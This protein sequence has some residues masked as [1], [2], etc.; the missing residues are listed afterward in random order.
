M[1][2][3]P[4]AHQ[5]GVQFADFVTTAL[6][7]VVAFFLW[8]NLKTFFPSL[9]LGSS[10]H[11]GKDDLYLILAMSFLWVALFNYQRAYSYQRFTSFAKELAIVFRTVFFGVLI[12]VCWIFVF[13]VSYIPRSLI[14]VFGATNLCML[15]IEKRFMFL[16]AQWIRKRGRNR[17]RSLI[18]GWNEQTKQLLSLANKHPGWGLDVVGVLTEHDGHQ[19][20][21]DL[22]AKIIGSH[23]Q[24]EAVLK[25]QQI[26][27]VLITISIQEFHKIKQVLEACEREGVQTRIISDFLGDIAKNIRADMVFGLPIISIVHTRQDEFQLFIKRCIDVA[28]SFFLLLL[29]SPLLLVVAVLIKATSKGPVLIVQERV[30]LN[31]RHFRFFKFRSMVANADRLKGE[32]SRG[33]EMTGAVFKMKKDPRITPVGRW[34]RRFSLDELPQLW[35]V[36]IGDMSL[37][38]P[39]PPLPSELPK[40]E[41]WQRRKFSVK[42]GLTCLWQ[43][44]GRNEISD[45]DEWMALDL[46]YIDNWSL[47]LD[48]KILLR[49]VPAVVSGRGAY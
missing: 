2:W 7:F 21:D 48:I 11:I 26:G 30:G 31:R 29:L 42:P 4:T 41:S 47:W 19:S 43:I 39:R 27:E 34:L 17:K 44:N 24:I 28:G 35:N 8:L 3:Q 16:V 45:F 23:D 9:P 49:T 15:T 25:D 1:L 6:S 10:V 36:L 20:M 46:E 14:A 37:V 12:L 5:R 32:L 13:R 18:V 40:F 38:G 22:E 33:N